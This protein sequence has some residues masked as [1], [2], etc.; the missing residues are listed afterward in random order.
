M[1][2]VLLPARKWVRGGGS[3]RT[4]SPSTCARQLGRSGPARV[5]LPDASVIACR[6]Q[7]MTLLPQC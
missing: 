6:D 4:A 7:F 2:A 3:R 1:R 5:R